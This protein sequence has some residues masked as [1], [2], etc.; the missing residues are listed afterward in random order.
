MKES[1]IGIKKTSPIYEQFS[2]HDEYKIGGEAVSQIPK[3]T[4]SD[5]EGEEHVVNYSFQSASENNTR[6]MIV[7]TSGKAP[8]ESEGY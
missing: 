7:S 4:Q 1:P 3:E 5:G 6:P 8:R 2:Y